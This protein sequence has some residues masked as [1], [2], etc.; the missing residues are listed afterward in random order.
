MF[1]DLWR[2]INVTWN[3]DSTYSDIKPQQNVLKKP[4]IFKID[5]YCILFSKK[6]HVFVFLC[7][8]STRQPCCSCNLKHHSFFLSQKYCNN[9][10]ARNRRWKAC[11]KCLLLL[12]LLFLL[13]TLSV[14]ID[15]ISNHKFYI[16]KK[17]DCQ[18]IEE[19][20]TP[21]VYNSSLLLIFSS[22]LLKWP[23]NFGKIGLLINENSDNH[24]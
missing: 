3:T 16:V 1:S 8:I 7:C 18:S 5:V 2:V 20:W 12:K 13:G 4:F 15:L 11:C 9:H 19:I 10:L 24:Y 22:H 17:A 14:K 23:G 21:C 6:M